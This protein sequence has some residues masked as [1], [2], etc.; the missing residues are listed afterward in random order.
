MVKKIIKT[1]ITG[2]SGFIGT[3]LIEKLLSNNSIILNLDKKEPQISS[4]FTFWQKCDL[5]N[6]DEVELFVKEFNPSFVI[7]LAGRT[8]I[9]GKN[10]DDYSIN[11]AGTKNLISA[12]KLC[13]VRKVIFTSTQFVHQCHGTPL[14]DDDYAPH[15]IYGESK[16]EME[17]L[18]KNSDLPFCWTIIRPTNIWGPWHP[19]YPFEFWKVLS[20]GKYFHPDVKNV[21]RSY[22]YVGNVIYQ[23]EK[24]L[25]LPE[26]RINREVLYV[27]DKPIELFDWVNGFSNALTGKNVRPIPKIF[28]KSLAL[29]GDLLK[30][31][32]IAFPITSSR[33]R[34]MTSSN[35]VLMDKTYE[36][37]GEPTYSLDEGIREAVEWLKIYHP[38]LVKV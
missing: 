29:L 24:I 10:M 17:K 12:L 2:G 1:L 34:S 38:E 15:T 25:E 35:P 31:L 20:E 21:L 18:I 13:T 26:E 7:H 8:D 19:R 32:K 11:I 37:L 3:N 36:L 5:L 16:V 4:H 30:K 9:E 23:I 22:G 14:D 33:Y 27:G 28:V 6:S